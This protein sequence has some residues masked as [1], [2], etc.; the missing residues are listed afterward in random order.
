MTASP[1]TPNVDRLANEDYPESTGRPSP[2]TQERSGDETGLGPTTVAPAGLSEANE[3]EHL[4]Q[5][6]ARF[7]KAYNIN[8]DRAEDR[9]AERQEPTK[10]PASIE[11]QAPAMARAIVTPAA[12]PIKARDPEKPTI[13]PEST[14]DLRELRQ[15]VNTNFRRDIKRHAFRQSVGMMRVH[16]TLGLVSII[17]SVG[18]LAIA[19]GTKSSA[20]GLGATT[21]VVGTVA[22]LRYLRLIR[23]NGTASSRS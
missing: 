19:S 20:Y 17:C 8:E 9:P 4:K 21:C 13:A 12:A 18:L 16:L 11:T 3:D 6:M 5:Y 7:F 10:T 14:E 22:C 1:V 15:L 23:R 2:E